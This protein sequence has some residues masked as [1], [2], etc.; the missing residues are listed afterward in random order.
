[1]LVCKASSEKVPYFF[2]VVAVLPGLSFEAKE[3]HPA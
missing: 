3:I 1:M 2:A